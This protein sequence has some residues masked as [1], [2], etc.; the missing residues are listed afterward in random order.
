MKEWRWRTYTELRLKMLIFLLDFGVGG[1]GSCSRVW[2]AERRSHAF[3]TFV[4]A[5]ALDAFQ[6][7]KLSSEP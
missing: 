1:L 3:A 2:T 5:A 4:S 7:V 6:L